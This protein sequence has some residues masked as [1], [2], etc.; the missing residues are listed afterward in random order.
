M[1]V[2][3]IGLHTLLTDA[4]AW[5]YASGS[6]VD[7]DV[8]KHALS[9]DMQGTMDLKKQVTDACSHIHFQHIVHRCWDMLDYMQVA[10]P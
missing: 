4:D 7:V 8:D 10:V 2:H 6:I 9:M 3:T 1:H 5:W